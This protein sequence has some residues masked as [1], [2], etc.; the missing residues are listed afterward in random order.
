[1][2]TEL[3]FRLAQTSDLDEILIP[4]EG[5]YDGQDNLPVRFHNWMQMDNVAVMLAPSHERKTCWTGSVLGC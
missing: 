3:T 2:S 4:S 5:V 1:M